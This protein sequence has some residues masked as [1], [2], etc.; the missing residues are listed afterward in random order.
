[1]LEFF[2]IIEMKGV[3]REKK[4]SKKKHIK[5][6]SYGLEIGEVGS[7]GYGWQWWENDK[8]NRLE[9]QME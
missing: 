1:M 3:T 2:E 9:I 4:G 7:I 6:M 5:Q 8:V